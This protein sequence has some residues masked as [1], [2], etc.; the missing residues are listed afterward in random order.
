MWRTLSTYLLLI[1][2]LLG[3]GAFAWLTRN[4]DSPAAARAEG[5]PV[6][7]P[8]VGK[9]RSLYLPPNQPA[10]AVADDD[11]SEAP[12]PEPTVDRPLDL[13]AMQRAQANRTSSRRA[14]A[15]AWLGPGDQLLE[16][17]RQGAALVEKIDAFQQV[18]VL[19]RRGEWLRVRTDR[20]GEGWVRPVQRAAA[21]EPPLGN[22]T[23]P[24]RPLPGQTPDPE[25]LEAAMALLGVGGP[26]GEVGPYGLFTDVADAGLVTT[27]DRL[28]EGLDGAYRQRYGLTPR[29]SAAEAV[30]FF[31]SERSYRR[32]QNRERSL[33]DLPAGG[34]AG[35]GLVAFYRG[36]R[37]RD[38]LLST[39]AHEVGHLLNRRAL[40]PAL[41]PWLDEGLADDFGACRIDASG[42]LD[43]STLGGS[44]VR[45]GSMVRYFG[46][47]AALRLLTQFRDRGELLPLAEL[48]GL[49]WEDFV[50]SDYRE[51]YYSHSGFFVRYLLEGRHGPGF[52]TFLRQ[53]AGGG[54]VGGGALTGSLGIDWSR[55]EAE[56]STWL[57]ELA[58]AEAGYEGP[59]SDSS[60]R[61]IDGPSR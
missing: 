32:F 36:D 52:R 61:Q 54:A 3:F 21:G 20:R 34:H 40:G 22:A 26:A 31:E 15:M 7:G 28:A 38:E 16:Q 27:F 19:E 25:R 33:V 29:G 43:P 42:K 37:R 49:D 5:W 13:T 41:P 59:T 50:R 11:L 12:A 51:L 35:Y 56:F 48:V 47:P 46:P 24:P 1:S 18:T 44:T 53:V 23:E 9:V 60:S 10:E 30:V 45:E 55:L 4:P 14:G 58:R 6:V 39:L 57:T 2:L 8:L 17:R